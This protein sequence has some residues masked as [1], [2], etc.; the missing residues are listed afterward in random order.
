MLVAPE[1]VHD[2]IVN[3]LN[4][5]KQVLQ[6]IQN[7]ASLGLNTQGKIDFW[8]DGDLFDDLLDV[9][10][11]DI[12]HLS[13]TRNFIEH[14]SSQPKESHGWLQVVFRQ[15]RIRFQEVFVKKDIQTAHFQDFFEHKAEDPWDTVH[16]RCLLKMLLAAE[17]YRTLQQTSDDTGDSLAVD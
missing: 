7:R 1:P 9:L 5:A 13:S 17:T 8:I 3:D 4:T 6:I 12:H 2:V 10:N 14:A 16:V 11:A 15:L